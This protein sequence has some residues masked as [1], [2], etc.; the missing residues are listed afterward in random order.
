MAS[1][2][3]PPRSL[4]PHAWLETFLTEAGRPRKHPLLT[5]QIGRRRRKATIPTRTFPGSQ[6]DFR[7]SIAN[8]RL[9]NRQSK[10]I[11]R[12]LLVPLSAESVEG[13]GLTKENVKQLLLDWTL[14]QKPRSRG[15]LGVREAAQRD[16]QKRFNNLLHHVTPD[17]L[18]ASFFDL[19]KSASPGIDGVTWAQYAEDF[20]TRID[21]LHSRIRGC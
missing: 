2:M 16:K 4:R 7:F 11:N 10:I 8:F 17:L 20:E 3:S 14:R 21:D 5:P 12:K 15:L 19:K 9:D 18:R 1:S 13:R 6:T